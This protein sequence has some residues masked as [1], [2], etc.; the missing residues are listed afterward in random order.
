MLIAFYRFFFYATLCNSI[1]STSS[2]GGRGRRHLRSAVT[3]QLIVP[4]TMTNYETAVSLLMV[5][6]CSIATCPAVNKHNYIVAVIC[7]QK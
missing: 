2:C 5:Q 7:L 4:R 3:R 1:G 6:P